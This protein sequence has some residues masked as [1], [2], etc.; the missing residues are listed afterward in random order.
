MSQPTSL[1]DA[2]ATFDRVSRAEQFR[3]AEEQR[4][5]IL[6]RFPLDSWPQLAL[7][8]FALGQQGREDTYC[9][10]V[11]FRSKKLGS[12]SGGSARKLIIYKH[13][14]K[15]GWFFSDDEYKDEHEAWEAVRAGFVQAF[16]LAK[17]NDWSEIDDIPALRIGPALRTKT[18][19]IYFPQEVLPVYSLSHIKHFLGKLS[20][21]IEKGY[22]TVRHNRKLLD[23]LKDDD[24]FSDW[25]T[26][27]IASFL[28][29]WSHPQKA[30]KIRKIAPGEGAR[31]WDDCLKDGFICVGWDDVGDLTEFEDK[32]EF[33]AA[34]RAAFPNYNK[35]KQTT[36]ANELWTLMELEEGDLIVANRGTSRVV[37]IGTVTDEGY[38]FRPDR[39]EYRHVVGVKWGPVL[40]KEIP[41]QK[42]WGLV[43]VAKVSI[44]LYQAISDGATETEALPVDS[45]FQELD[46]AI[47]RK[48]QI[49]LYGP[50]GTGKTY[51]AR[52]FGVWWLLN[53]NGKGDAA[54]TVLNPAKFRAAESSLSTSVLNHRVW[55]LVANPK[56]WSWDNLSRDGKVDFRYGRLKR[57]YPQVQVGDLVIGYQS[58]P[59][60]KLMAVAKIGRAFSADSEGTPTIGVEHVA[61]LKNG[62]SYEELCS[63]PILSK[64]E[65]IRFNNQGTLFALT[66]SESQCLFERLVEN[67]NE[68]LWDLVDRDETVGQLTRITFHASYSYEDFIEGFR[69]VA[70]SSNGLSLR[71]ED[72]VFKRVCREASANP[73]RRYLVMIDEINRANMA[74]VFGELLTLL[75]IDKRGLTVTLP[76]SKQAFSIPSNVYLLATMNTAD[77]SIKLLDAA[78]RRRFSFVE[79]MPDSSL[80]EG[81]EID[82]LPLDT[83]LTEIN[84]RVSI[85]FGPEKQ[86]GH[87]FLMDGEEA[88]GDADE[89][90]RRFRQDILPL[91]QEY[92]YDDY[93]SLA[94]LLGI[95]IVNTES[96]CLNT[97]VTNDSQ[98]LLAALQK[99]VTSSSGE[100][101]A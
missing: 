6:E 20:V 79:M 72:G 46:D 70:E 81:E 3:D 33:T 38:A 22:S 47:T 78:L 100:R 64:S 96:F 34:F 98:K 44:S 83:F 49:I 92:C 11:E 71:L 56:E 59:D 50:P 37:A 31:F 29:H 88:I 25:S 7:E 97:E 36:K 95:A 28:Y 68:M 5:A 8:D 16:Q 10:W 89:F 69:P 80:L 51:Q 63:D 15:P 77:R 87:S 93:A 84:R 42:R 1:E 57:N 86:I 12:M 9:R 19:H 55:W 53:H 58:T 21:P 90:A 41:T 43:T 99:A 74:K 60:K 23:K 17:E 26:T 75:E 13:K 52:R 73:D 40:D 66:E 94:E 61:E 91:L 101:D 18:L 45:V 24:R 2:L 14:K 82:G 85:K 62:L 4:A 67:G 27:E 76:Q 32:E 39:N 35:S 30:P 48:G 65:P 54:R